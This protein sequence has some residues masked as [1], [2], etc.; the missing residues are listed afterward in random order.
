MVLHDDQRPLSD[1]ELARP[2]ENRA[3]RRQFIDAV[4]TDA[5]VEVAHRFLQR[6]AKERVSAMVNAWRNA[7]IQG[8]VADI[9]LIAYAELHH[10]LAS[11]P[12]AKPVQT[13]HDSVVIECDSA[14]AAVVVD[15]V[16]EALERASLE[17]CPDVAPKVDVDVRRSLAEEHIVL[18]AS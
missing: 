14:D 3:L 15:E 18:P 1:A 8:G 9:M 4:A 11:F 5:G 10:L 2:F 17:L 12:G 6:A 16:R 13:V 7:P